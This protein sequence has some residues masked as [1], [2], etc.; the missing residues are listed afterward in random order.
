MPGTTGGCVFVAFVVVA[1]VVDAD[2]ATAGPARPPADH[3]A[4]RTLDRCGGRASRP[5]PIP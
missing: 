1:F 2:P 3:E 4:D 5:T